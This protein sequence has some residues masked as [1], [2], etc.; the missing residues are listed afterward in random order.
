MS[1][2]VHSF[3]DPVFGSLSTQLRATLSAAFATGTVVNHQRQAKFYIAFML[4]AHLNPLFPTVSSLLHYA[5]LLAN[6]FK[7]VLSVK[8]YLSGAKTFVTSVGGDPT[9]FLARPLQLVIRGLSRLS[10]HVPQNAPALDPAS[11]RAVC[12]VL[13]TLGPDA[14]VARA[15]LLFGFVT[16]LRQSNFLATQSGEVHLIRRDAVRSTLRGLAIHVASTKTL[17]PSNTV[18][19]PVDRANN[20]KYCPVLAYQAAA[21]ATPAPGS[22][23]LFLT[24]LG[25][26]LTA[27]GL[28]SLIRSTLAAM[29][30]PA[31]TTARCAAQAGDNR[32]DVA[33]HRTW[34]GSG[35]NAYVPRT[36]FTSVP[37][38][39]TKVLGPLTS[40]H[41]DAR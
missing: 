21:R 41:F 30:H 39:M 20:P 32:A 4:K 40:E 35:I 28:T 36:M 18:I 23:P 33:A 37:Q 38:T 22:S 26:P 31:A 3:P 11:I 12:D 7:S 14:R 25:R 10:L 9:P 13:W 24:T 16:F 34:S 27:Q 5:Q 2:H 19:I 6:S 29:G 15:A 1:D 17:T 8:N